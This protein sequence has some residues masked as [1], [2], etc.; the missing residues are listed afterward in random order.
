[1]KKRAGALNVLATAALILVFGQSCNPK[2]MLPTAPIIDFIKTPSATSQMTATT[3]KT[4]G[5]SPTET[6]W[7]SATITQTIS[8][9]PT[10][11]LFVSPTISPT[12]TITSTSTPVAPEGS[13][14][15]SPAWAVM[16]TT[17][18]TWRIVY[19]AG[20]TTWAAS[21]GYGT[22]K[23]T[24]PA[25][26]SSPSLSSTDPGYFTVSVSNGTLF[27]YTVNGMQILLQVR[28]L[29]TGA[30]TITIN[31]GDRSGGGPGAAAAANA[32]NFTFAVEMT[33]DGDI[34]APIDSSP[35]LDIVT[36]L[37][38]ATLSPQ[39]A[40][41]GLGGNTAELTYIP[42]TL[43]GNGTLQITI[44]AG[45]SQPSLNS[46]A[47]G[48]FT[49]SVIGG[50]LT[51]VMTESMNIIVSAS[52]I[53]ND[54]GRIIV[55]YGSRS[56]TGPGFTAP[57][58]AGNYTFSV[59]SDNDGTNIHQI[60]SSPLFAVN[61]AT[62]T[63][64]QTFTVTQTV[65]PTPTISKTFTVS[66]TVTKTS[67][68]SKTF[69]PTFSMTQTITRTFTVSPTF[70]VTPTRTVS[71]TSSVTKT[72]TPT[73]SVTLTKTATPTKTA[74][75][76][77]T[78]TRTVTDTKT[79]TPTKTGTF[80]QTATVTP[81][82]TITPTFTP[83]EVVFPD[84]NLDNAVRSAIGKPTGIIYST[85][86][87]SLTTLNAFG[88]GIS[89]LTGLDQCTSL[90][91]LSLYN[92]SITSIAPLAGLTSLN[93]VDLNSNQVADI[94]ALVQ[95][96]DAGG[97]TSGAQV[98]LNNNPLSAQALNTDI[99]YLQSKGVVVSFTASN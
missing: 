76:T 50:T 14:S 80:T 58:A 87:Y 60:A 55:D 73:Y 25:G 74:S 37:G 78:S 5:P 38:S 2:K 77:F 27:S 84:P 23:I 48:Y 67:I 46:G 65:T 34:T 69:T 59:A 56:G 90:V 96:A 52:G 71:P 36:P 8:S 44:P 86:L 75:P 21:P 40:A 51:Q 10:M 79:V 98:I 6:E 7:L 97:L 68:A 18:N 62:A 82:F 15:I 30:G 81:T 89:D 92:N 3:T 83:H 41:C 72:I 95:N 54:T 16:N 61:P 70:T 99:P 39:T 88:S 4:E 28:G 13:A 42:Q 94:T 1:M 63:V 19:S 93:Y 29:I 53:P 49:V 22:L 57:Y 12:I 66:P 43:W 31:F 85:D 11:T 24:V 47:P 9:T 64:T 33:P 35:S 91:I 45:F 32:G 20:T 26:F 17:G